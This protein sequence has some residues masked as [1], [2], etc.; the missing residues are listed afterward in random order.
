[1]IA[2]LPFARRAFLRR[3]IGEVDELSGYQFS[4]P[5]TR[6]VAFVAIFLFCGGKTAM[7]FFF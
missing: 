2:Q 3:R 4:G 6:G 5:A 1:V 7:H